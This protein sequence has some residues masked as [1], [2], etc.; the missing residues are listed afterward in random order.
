[1]PENKTQETVQPPVER[2]INQQ[3]KQ[4]ESLSDPIA[5]EEMSDAM[6]LEWDRHAA[7]NDGASLAGADGQSKNPILNGFLNALDE[8]SHKQDDKLESSTIKD[9][10]NQLQNRISQ[11][12]QLPI[13]ERELALKALDPLISACE[14]QILASQNTLSSNEASAFSDMLNSIDQL[15]V[16]PL[17]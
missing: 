3:P 4:H 16:D 7:K 6:G 11:I 14:A 5:R 17:V 13:E 10:L 9:L 1:M 15:A 8:T 12:M 2:L